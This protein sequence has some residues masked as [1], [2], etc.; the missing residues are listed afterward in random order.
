MRKEVENLAYVVVSVRHSVPGGLPAPQI[1]G[2]K[3]PGL[4]YTHCYL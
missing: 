4:I 1:L 2:R 3:R